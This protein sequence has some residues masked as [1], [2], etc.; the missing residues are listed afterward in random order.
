MTPAI[1]QVVAGFMERVLVFAASQL[2]SHRPAIQSEQ[3]R[4]LLWMAAIMCAAF[5]AFVALDDP[6]LQD[7]CLSYLLAGC[8]GALGSALVS[9][10]NCKDACSIGYHL[11]VAA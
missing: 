4:L 6:C 10:V 3:S 7:A 9:F 2:A 8:H 5:D 11:A 1:S